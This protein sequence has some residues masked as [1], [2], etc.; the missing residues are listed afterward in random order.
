ML[1]YDVVESL[2]AGKGSP[3]HNED[4]LVILPHVVALADGATSCSALD[5]VA[6]GVL[7]A[8]AV[9]EAVQSLSPDWTF[10][11]LVDRAT[12]LLGERLRCR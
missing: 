1:A 5:G 11:Y 8:E 12:A 9:V 10:R 6:G 4:R 3:A 2:C 7:A